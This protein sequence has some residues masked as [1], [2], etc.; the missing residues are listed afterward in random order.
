MKKLIIFLII[1]TLFTGCAQARICSM[2]L[3]NGS[4]LGLYDF[5]YTGQKIVVN[6]TLD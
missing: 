3:E 5:E 1:L 4:F 6:R 2:P